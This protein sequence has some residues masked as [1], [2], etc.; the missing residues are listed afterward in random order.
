LTFGED[1]FEKLLLAVRKYCVGLIEF[2]V[3]LFEFLMLMIARLV[4]SALGR[5]GN[6]VIS[7]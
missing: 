1:R 2:V 3:E 4:D 6:W 7:I 5:H